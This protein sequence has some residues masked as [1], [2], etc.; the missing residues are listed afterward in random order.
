MTTTMLRMKDAALE[1]FVQL[2]CPEARRIQAMDLHGV[3]R[4]VPR[5]DEDHLRAA[6]L[7][8]CRAHDIGDDDGFSAMFSFVEGWQASYPE[9]TGYLIPTLF[10]CAARFGDDTLHARAVEAADWLRRWQ[11]PDGSF[12]GGF[13]D[14]PGPARV[15]N[16]GQALLGLVRTYEQTGAER[17]LK[18]AVR[19]G[20]W[21]VARQDAD[22][23]WRKSTLGESPHAY[24]A[25]TGWALARLAQMT[26]ES[27]FRTAGVQAAAWALAQ[28][29]D[30]GWFAN[31][32]FE[33][34]SD[35][36]TLHTIGYATRGL[37]EVGAAAE[38][39]DFV[40]GAVKTARAIDRIWR[41]R[42]QIAGSYRRNWQAAGAWRCLPGEAQLAIIWMR[43][44]RIGW[45]SEFVTS[46]SELLEL[47]KAAQLI[48]ESNMDLCGG[49]SGSLPLNAPYERYCLVNWGAKFLIDA[50]NL[51]E[52]RIGE[53]TCD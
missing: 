29:G 39:E 41:D 48:D 37:L 34:G 19:T 40:E 27:Q 12:S 46:A 47:V 14:R 11:E 38:R 52:G 6:L 1:T 2:L 17:F 8:L 24:N 9:T 31:N 42:K 15:F 32:S 3:R 28:Q 10:D 36:A 26:G 20:C 45:T 5:T 51:H 33:Q 16:T 23:A 21:L 43:L 35:A 22:G 44:D 13:A 53:P 49:V 30:F 50:L 18:A 4:S 7:W 25:R